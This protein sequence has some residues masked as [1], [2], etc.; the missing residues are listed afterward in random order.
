MRNVMIASSATSNSSARTT[1]L[2]ALATDGTSANDSRTE[3]EVT[4][5]SRRA[6]VTG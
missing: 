6:W 2:K 1:R 4:S 5:P 3:G